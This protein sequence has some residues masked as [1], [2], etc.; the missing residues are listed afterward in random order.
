M[1]KSNQKPTDQ[2]LTK[3]SLLSVGKG[4]R[5]GEKNIQNP[6]NGYGLYTTPN[7]MRRIK[8]AVTSLTTHWQNTNS[9]AE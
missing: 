4:K 1:R 6:F 7:Q 9:V 5:E 3:T 2:P 8:Q